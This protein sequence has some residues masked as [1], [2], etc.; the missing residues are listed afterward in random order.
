MEFKNDLKTNINILRNHLLDKMKEYLIE[1]NPVFI[2]TLQPNHPKNFYNYSEAEPYLNEVSQPWTETLNL[3]LDFELG[4]DFV[5]FSLEKMNSS[6]SGR[7]IH[8]FI[9]T[10]GIYMNSSLERIECLVKK[11][12]RKKI[13]KH[14]DQILEVISEAIKS[15]GLKELRNT[16]AHGRYVGTNTKIAG[17][18]TDFYWEPNSIIRLEINHLSEWHDSHQ[19]SMEKLKSSYSRQNEDFLKFINDLLVHINILTLNK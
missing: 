12:I 10:F 7:E 9:Q 17:S 13:I 14:N 2:E 16:S 3:L 15:K 19:I 5:N 18:Q 8:F 11:L 4:L 1:N 6:N